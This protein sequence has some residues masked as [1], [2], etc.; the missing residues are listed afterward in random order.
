M[1]KAG[2]GKKPNPEDAY[3]QAL[4]IIIGKKA[5]KSDRLATKVI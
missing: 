5:D 4:D 3:G 1:L 2:E